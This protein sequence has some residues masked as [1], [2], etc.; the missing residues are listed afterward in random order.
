MN[1][2]INTAVW[3]HGRYNSVLPQMKNNFKGKFLLLTSL[4]LLVKIRTLNFSWLR[5][6]EN[7]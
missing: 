6:I 5:R 1:S 4:D 3:C 2:V 7:K